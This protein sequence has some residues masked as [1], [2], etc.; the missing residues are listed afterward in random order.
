MTRQL[1]KKRKEKQSH[2]KRRQQESGK[3][4]GKQVK[5]VGAVPRAAL[6]PSGKRQVRVQATGERKRNKKKDIL[7]EFV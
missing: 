4:E 7:F 5:A 3:E 2:N 1:C 6:E